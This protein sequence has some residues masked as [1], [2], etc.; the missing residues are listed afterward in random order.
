MKCV[1]GTEIE[2][3]KR[4]CAKCGR[5]HISREE[6]EVALQ[7][8]I[9]LAD[10]DAS[11]AARIVSG[12]WDVAWGGGIVRDTVTMLAGFPGAGK[13]TL[14]LQVAA[15]VSALEKKTALY[16]AKEE[17]AGQ[18]KL[19]ALRLQMPIEAQ[20]MFLIV[21]HLDKSI[22]ELLESYDSGI[23]VV[24][25]LPALAGT[26]PTGMQPAYEILDAIR[27]YA[28]RKT[29]PVIVINHINKEGDFAGQAAWQHLVDV[30]LMLETRFREDDRCVS[31]LGAV[32]NRHGASGAFTDFDM[33]ERGLVLAPPEGIGGNNE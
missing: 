5:W 28:L 3:G 7:Q 18:I 23:V 10:V 12:P 14:M 19:R 32:K 13:S 24:D 30:T 6:I 29:V 2:A 11:E 31:R 4:Q 15:A 8:T 25:S 26:G 27:E 1:C 16:I 22:G 21:P 17:S 9:N 33:T 20:R